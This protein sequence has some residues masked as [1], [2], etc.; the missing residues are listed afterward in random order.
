M[1]F[2]SADMTFKKVPLLISGIRSALESLPLSFDPLIWVSL[3]VSE[4]ALAPMGKK[5]VSEEG[6]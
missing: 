5:S 3:W 4:M 6:F 2:R 1:R